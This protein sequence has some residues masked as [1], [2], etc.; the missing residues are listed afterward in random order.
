[1]PQTT[2]HS[3][4][5]AAYPILA[6]VQKPGG[7]T[8]QATTP[9]KSGPPANTA[10]PVASATSLSVGAAGVASVTNG[11]WTHSPTSYTYQW[12][13][14][15]TAIAGATTNSHTL[16]AADEGFNLSCNVT[17]VNAAG[18]STVASNSIGPVTA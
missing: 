15:G 18:S 16:V 1:M 6:P 3:L 12:M 13:R 5:M 9:F 17:A 2:Y 7:V 10:A 4:A 11:T 14:G 8:V